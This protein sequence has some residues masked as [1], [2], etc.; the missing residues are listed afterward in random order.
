MM[1]LMVAL[2]RFFV[3]PAHFITPSIMS[4][5]IGS[6]LSGAHTARASLRKHSTAL[7][8]S[9]A[10][11]RSSRRM[12]LVSSGTVSQSSGSVGANTAIKRARARTAAERMWGVC[13][14]SAALTMRMKCVFEGMR[15]LMDTSKSKAASR[16]LALAS[17]V[18]KITSPTSEGTAASAVGGSKQETRRS[19][20]RRRIWRLD[21]WQVSKDPVSKDKSSVRRS[22]LSRAKLG[23]CSH[24]RSKM[25]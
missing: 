17:L 2:N 1:S 9:R 12:V 21:T 16:H 20:Q 25:R 11:S 8:T 19:K 14:A 18:H 7:T 22:S 6:S 23:W 4:G 13:A 3:S 5:K 15:L 10:C 24:T